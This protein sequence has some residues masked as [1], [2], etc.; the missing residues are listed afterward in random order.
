MIRLTNLADYAVVLMCVLAQ[1][2]D[3]LMNA[4]DLAATS[5]IP[6]PTVAKILGAVSRAGLLASQRGIGG[7]FQ[8]AREPDR[9]T[10]ADIIEAVDGPIAI[11][12]CV[13]DAPGDCGIEAICSMRG[14]WHAINHAVKR[15]LSE[16]TLAEF[17]APIPFSP[18]LFEGSDKKSDHGRIR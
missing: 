17:A 12:N 3:R 7:G 9:I 5:G 11:T 18:E 16:V 13:E 6:A 8:L 14:H 15:A 4:A 1:N 2:R 10:V